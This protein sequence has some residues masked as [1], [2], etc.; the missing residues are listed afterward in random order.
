MSTKAKLFMVALVLAIIIGGMAY[1]AF[2]YQ[3][4]ISFIR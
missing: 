3:G 1:A 2:F 4:E